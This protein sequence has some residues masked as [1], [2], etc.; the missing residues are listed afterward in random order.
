MKDLGQSILIKVLVCSAVFRLVPVMFIRM[1]DTK[2]S[3]VGLIVFFIAGG[4]MWSGCFICS[5]TKCN[6][7]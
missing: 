3:R 5:Y 6:Q 4:I 2:L 1:K 7:S